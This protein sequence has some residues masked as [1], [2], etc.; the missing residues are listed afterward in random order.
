[1]THSGRL[2]LILEVSGIRIPR[3]SDRFMMGFD[4]HRRSN[5][6]KAPT[7]YL[8]MNAL[9]LHPTHLH[10]RSVM[11]FKILLL[12]IAAFIFDRSSAPPQPAPSASDHRQTGTDAKS[13]A[14]LYEMS[15]VNV[16]RWTRVS[17]ETYG[18]LLTILMPRTQV[19]YPSYRYHSGC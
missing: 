19:P 2:L 5:A 15:V 13:L 12:F 6:E 16:T 17:I 4:I 7:D 3:Y 18:S 14:G 8:I 9:R 1:M 10:Q 11:L